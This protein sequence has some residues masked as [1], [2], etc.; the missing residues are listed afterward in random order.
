MFFFILQTTIN[1][2]LMFWFYMHQGQPN[3]LDGIQP[4]VKSAL[5]KA[6]KEQSR[7]RVVRVADQITLPGVKKAPKKRIAA[8]LEPAEEGGKNEDDT[9]DESE[10]ENTSD[11]EEL[12]K[13]FG[14]Y[15]YSFNIDWLLL[16]IFVRVMH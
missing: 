10:E 1:L 5:T 2:G 9:F 6:Y 4:A 3:P 13:L 7:S 16:T 11:T 12:G 15:Y 8:I 14:F